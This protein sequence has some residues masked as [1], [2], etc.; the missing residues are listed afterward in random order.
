VGNDPA[1]LSQWG[2][3]NTGQSG[4]TSGADIGAAAAWNTTTTTGQVIVAVVDT[5][6]DYDHPDLYLNIW[7]NPGEIPVDVRS[8][9]ADVD[10]DGAITF[11]DLND[12]RNQGSGKAVDVNRDGRISAGDLLARRDQGGWADGSDDNRDGFTDDLI[13]WDFAGNTNR[14][15]DSDGHGTHVAGTIGAIGNN[16]IGVSGVAWNSQIMALKFMGSN[17]SGSVADAIRALDYAVAHGAKIS[18]HSYGGTAPYSPLADAIAR[19]QSAGHIVIAAAGNQQRNN[20]AT[21]YYPASYG[22]DNVLSVAASDRNDRLGSFSNY[23][24]NSVDL[25]APGAS[26]LSTLPGGKYGTYSGTSMAAAYVSGAAAVV[27]GQHPE[28]SYRQ[29]I[30]RILS[31]VDRVAALSDKVS[32]GGRLDLGRAITPPATSQPPATPSPPPPS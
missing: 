28:W 30:D 19:A 24:R 7:L 2:L 4:G 14:P 29:V 22:H 5:G 27:W 21:P 9:L 20:D 10:G 18:N 13:G 32:T 15:T 17:G 8:R 23:G 25:A 1:L 3:N 12:S 11:R 16:G 6:I 31:T 26:I